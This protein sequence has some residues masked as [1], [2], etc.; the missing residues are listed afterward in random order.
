MAA[1]KPARRKA[2]KQTA[3][4]RRSRL[5]F[6]LAV[7]AVVVFGPP[8][9]RAVFGWGTYEEYLPNHGSPIVVGDGLALNVRE[10][11]SGPPV[12]LVHGLPSNAT[13]WSR[14][15]DLLAARGFRAIAYDRVG[16][17]YSSRV[18]VG[19]GNYTVASNASELLGLLDA[20]GLEKAILVGWSYGGGVVQAVAEQ[21]PNRVAGLVLLSSVGPS[22][23]SDDDSM[24]GLMRSPLA[25]PLLSWI[26]AVP[27]LSKV[28]VWDGL[29]VAFA[30]EDEIPDGWLPYTQAMMALPGTLDSYI[31]EF[32]RLDA[33]S[34]DPS[35]LKTPTLIVHGA[36]DRSVSL[37]VAKDLEQRIAGS[38]LVVFGDA[39]HMI[40]V[41]R[42][43]R[44]AEEIARFAEGKF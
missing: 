8:L 27:P 39:G 4:L 6:L 44:L 25:A 15:P 31:A 24:S 37:S 36:A 9:G 35:Q 11:G 34:S 3:T 30:T 28:L 38:K 17:G 12:V 19:N 14:T 5:V 7:V 26:A 20:L 42:S 16:Y 2:T 22:F 32:R 10:R 23:Q 33:S 21:A 13:D 18:E 41:T 1:K 29:R 43:E 40:P